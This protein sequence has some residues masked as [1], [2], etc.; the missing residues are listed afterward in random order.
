MFLFGVEWFPASCRL[1]EQVTVVFYLGILVKL[2][3]KPA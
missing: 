3:D 2:I 1:E